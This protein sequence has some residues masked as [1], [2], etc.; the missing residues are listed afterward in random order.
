MTLAA[1]KPTP[2]PL[3]SPSPS[4]SAAGASLSV[5]VAQSRPGTPTDPASERKIREASREFEAMLV[6]QMLTAAG[7]GGTG[8]DGVYGGMEVDAIAKA[9]TQGHGLGLAQKIADALAREEHRRK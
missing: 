6:R 8:K 2:Q 7:F 4:A 5:P 3:L 1:I 9:V